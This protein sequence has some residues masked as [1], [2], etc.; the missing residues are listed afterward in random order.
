[1]T[2]NVESPTFRAALDSEIM[3]IEEARDALSDDSHLRALCN[4]AVERLRLFVS[5]DNAP[6]SRAVPAALTPPSQLGTVHSNKKGRLAGTIR[7]IAVDSLHPTGWIFATKLLEMPLDAMLDPSNVMNAAEQ[8]EG[9][10]V[11]LTGYFAGD[12]NMR[13]VADSIEPQ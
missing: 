7:R 9:Q 4:L 2:S 1:M 13:L 11:L 8:L 6:A 3:A 12:A 10:Q 5:Q